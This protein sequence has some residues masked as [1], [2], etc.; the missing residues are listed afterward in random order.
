VLRD[1][2]VSLLI[3]VR[4]SPRSRANPVFNIETL[5]GE[6]EKVQIGYQY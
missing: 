1:A 5:P 6:L 2:Q 4:T 3:D